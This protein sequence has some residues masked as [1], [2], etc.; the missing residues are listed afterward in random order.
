V[1]AKAPSVASVAPARGAT[2]VFRGV[3]VKAAF[4][5]RVYNVESNFKLYNK[6]SGTAVAVAGSSASK[7]VLNPYE[8]LRPGTT[9][10][11]K[12]KTDVVDKVG[13]RLDQSPTQSGDQPMRWT[14]KIHS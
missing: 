13:H 10:V 1:D 12:V 2:G 11:A 9:Y 14:F 5:E 3:D 8:P 6:G 4:S 7:W